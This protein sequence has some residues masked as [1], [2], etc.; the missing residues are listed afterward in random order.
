[1]KTIMLMRHAKSSHN[2]NRDKD[3][4]LTH[5]GLEDA[6]EMGQYLK[7]T[8]N[9]PTEIISSPA[10]RAKQTV[11]KVTEQLEIP[12]GSISWNNDF[13][14]G[15]AADYLQA[16]EQAPKEADLILLVGHNP[17]IS[18]AGTALLKQS[19]GSTRRMSPAMLVCLEHP[20]GV[21]DKVQPHS[22]Q[23]RWT[24]TPQQLRNT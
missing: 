15:S 8:D 11:T 20:A 12:S 24:M 22:A 9:I 5:F 18:E 3:R 10:R 16:I 19:A 4:E 23:L 2:A 1:M 6:K 14:S 13:Y 7:E 21:W 17:S